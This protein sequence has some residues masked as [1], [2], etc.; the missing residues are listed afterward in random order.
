MAFLEVHANP[1]PAS[2]AAIPFLLD[3]QADLLAGLATRV[4]VPL[5][6]QEA[7]PSHPMARLTPVVEFQGHPYVAMVP[8]LA[9][10]ARHHLGAS[11]GD[12]GLVRADIIAALDLLITGI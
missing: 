10:V 9:G 4:V 3:I 12:L 5:Y 8:E 11:S 6:R 7:A 2:R 1:N